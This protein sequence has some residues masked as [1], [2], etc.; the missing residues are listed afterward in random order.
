VIANHPGESV[1]L[2]LESWPQSDFAAQVQRPLALARQAA[3][4]HIAE[5]AE[6]AGLPAMLLT[7]DSAL[8][9]SGRAILIRWGSGVLLT[10]AHLESIAT[11]ASDGRIWGNRS[12]SPDIWAFSGPVLPNFHRP[13]EAVFPP[14]AATLFRLVTG[15]DLCLLAA[16]APDMLND[17]GLTLPDAI[18]LGKAL[19]T[20]RMTTR[21]TTEILVIGDPGCERWQ[22]LERETACRVRLLGDSQGGLLAALLESSGPRRFVQHLAELGDAALINSRILF[23]DADY[24]GADDFFHSDMGDTS[25]IVH[26]GLRGFTEGLLAS[27]RPFVLGGESLLSSAIYLLVERAWQDQELARQFS[28][29]DA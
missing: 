8:P 5:V 13:P 12:Q 7:K 19:E 26:D 29:V 25:R 9:K 11:A 18:V 3:A 16:F 22:Y 17:A 27:G 10:P 6:Q 21:R 24:P 23:S 14:S 28:V 1:Q 20:M 4:I 2:L 15:G